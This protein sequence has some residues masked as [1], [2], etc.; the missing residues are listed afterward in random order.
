MPSKIEKF[1]DVDKFSNCYGFS[2]TEIEKGSPLK[3]E[4]EIRLSLELEE[5]KSKL[6]IAIDDVNHLK[7]ENKKLMQWKEE[8]DAFQNLLSVTQLRYK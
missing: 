2:Y 4:T 3:G 7:E 6:C 5:P 1:A 8:D